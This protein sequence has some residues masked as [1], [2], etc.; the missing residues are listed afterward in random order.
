MAK[1]MHISESDNVE[2]RRVLNVLPS[3]RV[4]LDWTYDTALTASSVPLG[5]EAA[6]PPSVDLRAGWWAVGDQEQSGSCVGWAS[7]DGLARY[8]FVKS[9]RIAQSD[10][11]SVR[12]TWMASKEFDE[13]DERPGSMIEAAGTSLKSAMDV[14]R[15]YG[16]VGDATLPMKLSKYMYL[17]DEKVFFAMAA[18][19]KVAS[20]FNLR[21]K[22]SDWRNWLAKNG[23][24]LAGLTVDETFHKAASTAGVLDSY[25][26][27]TASG[28]H[29]ITIVGYRPD[30]RFIIRN[31][32]GKAWGDKGYAY[33]SE[34]YIAA[35][36][37]DESY[38]IAL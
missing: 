5:A 27:S 14:L 17:G 29:A 3:K 30:G 19:N 23:P 33:A 15:K 20:Y 38:G 10:K 21:K 35:G 37:F 36:F 28:G 11:L 13:F 34:G 8:H 9:G 1:Q 2:H 7:T 25:R 24:I 31:S 16:A 32:W 12:F 18:K 26:S 4:D 22:A 6:L